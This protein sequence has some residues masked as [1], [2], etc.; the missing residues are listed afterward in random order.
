MAPQAYQV[1]QAGSDQSGGRAYED[2][3][4]SRLE[5][6]PGRYGKEYSAGIKGQRGNL[7]GTGLR[8]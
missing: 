1:S 5:L 4:Q 2:V 7:P 6:D 8:H 3:F